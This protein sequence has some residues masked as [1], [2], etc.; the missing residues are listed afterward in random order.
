MDHPFE[1]GKEYRNRNGI[2]E[3]L[4]IE[5]PEVRVRYEDG[6]EETLLITTQVLAWGM[7]QDMPEPPPPVVV[8]STPRKGKKPAK[9][10]PSKPSKQ[11]TLIAEILK[12]DTAIHDILTRLVIPPGQIDLFRLL[13][14]H[15][16]DY[17]SIQEIADK[18]RG[19]DRQSEQS[20]LRAFGNRIKGSSDERVKSVKPYNRLFFEDKHSGGETKLRIRPRVREI[21]QSYPKFYDFLINDSRSWLPDEFGSPQWT[22]TDDVHR[23]QMAYFGFEEPASD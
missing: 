18:V 8:K 10:R 23:R 9:K 14:Q 20:V 13:L 1:V 11:E 12:E 21:F 7:W 4:A 22:D 16:D 2:Y 6:R 3:V 5:A 17:F 15:P 19:G